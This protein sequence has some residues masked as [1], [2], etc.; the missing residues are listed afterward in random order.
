[1]ALD[2]KLQFTA[3]GEVFSK[4]P[5]EVFRRWSTA[6]MDISTSRIARAV[7]KRAPV[8]TGTT[9]RS[10]VSDTFHTHN[11]VVGIVTSN[12]AHALIQDQGASFSTMP[13]A[14]PLEL[15]VRRQ[16]MVKLPRRSRR[17]GKPGPKPSLKGAERRNYEIKRAAFAVR[18]Q[19]QRRGLPALRF[20]DKGLEDVR[21]EVEGMLKANLPEQIARELAGK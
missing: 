4:A 7:A 20:F 18:R 5:A 11:A 14:G 15:W 12:Q 21:I 9:R 13:K 17:K 6:Y 16:K 19:I 1:M 2:M 3:T 8:D 10:I